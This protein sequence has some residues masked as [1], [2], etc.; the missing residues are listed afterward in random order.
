[1][2]LEIKINDSFVPFE[3][4]PMSEKIALEWALMNVKPEDIKV[5][6]TSPVNVKT[7]KI[8]GFGF[9]AVYCVN[10]YTGKRVNVSAPGKF[11]KWS[12]E[13]K[14]TPTACRRQNVSGI[15]YNKPIKQKK[16]LKCHQ[17]QFQ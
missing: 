13:I 11:N 4:A 1:M 16:G 2:S 15:C 5:T 9:D 7:C 12:T 8:C 6:S 14:L 17:V 10:C 3:F